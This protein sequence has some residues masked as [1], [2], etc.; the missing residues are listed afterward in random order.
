MTAAEAGMYICTATSGDIRMDIP[1][2]LTVT[3]SVPFF[4]QAPRSYIGVPTLRN[5]YHDFD[6]EISFKPEQPDG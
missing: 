6:I 5:P 4:A 2:I 3:G 1:T